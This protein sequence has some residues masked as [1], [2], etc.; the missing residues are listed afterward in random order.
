MPKSSSNNR[1]LLRFFKHRWDRGLVGSQEGLGREK[2]EDPRALFLLFFKSNLGFN[3]H[4][5]I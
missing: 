2:Y 4:V 3:I 1:T 5:K